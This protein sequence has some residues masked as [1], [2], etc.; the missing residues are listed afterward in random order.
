ML[1][2]VEH[3]WSPAL[4]MVGQA[5]KEVLQLMS[6]LGRRNAIGFVD[7]IKPK[8]VTC[9]YQAVSTEKNSHSF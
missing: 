9:L 8:L 2:A 1:E 5:G 7:S 4:D 3:G 6:W